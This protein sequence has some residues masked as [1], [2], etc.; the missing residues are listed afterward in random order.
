MGDSVASVESSGGVGD[1]LLCRAAETAADTA[2]DSIATFSVFDSSCV[3]AS[4]AGFTAENCAL[5]CSGVLVPVLGLAS[6]S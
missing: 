4:V 1:P 3:V 2:A 5:A 6:V